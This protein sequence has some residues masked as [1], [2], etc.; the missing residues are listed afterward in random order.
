MYKFTPILKSMLWGGNKIA[1]YKGI[2]A[3]QERIGE[4]WELSG[5]AG[6]VS[7]VAEG[8]DAGMTLEELLAR[9]K[10]RLLGHKNF[11]RFGC[12]FPLLV[13]FIDAR[14]DL[15]IQVHPNDTLA[16]KRHGT[17][18][19]TEMWYVIAADEGARLY[20]GFRRPVTPQTYEASLAADTLTELLAAHPIAAGDVFYLPA[21]RIHSLGAGSFV[22]EI[23]QTSDLTYRIYDY[24]RRDTDGNLRELH[25]ELAKE[26]IDYSAEAEYRTQYDRRQEGETPLVAC[27]HFSTSLLDLTR[28]Y[29]LDRTA[30]DSFLVVICIEGHGILADGQGRRMLLHQG[31]TILVPASARTLE[32]TPEVPLKLL[33]SW[34]D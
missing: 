4:S 17:N 8:P 12:T 24:N 22:A 9:E 25:T 27:P 16:R 31:E 13:K 33:T 26:A 10:E 20:S 5:V 7:V 11:E 34:I 15:S 1:P 14:L 19:K 3:E 6:N 23:Q 18:G 30:S 28:P 2:A 32:I 21:G 29:T